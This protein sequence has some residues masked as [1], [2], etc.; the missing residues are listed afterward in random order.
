MTRLYLVRSKS[1]PHQEPVALSGLNL[2]VRAQAKTRGK[3]FPI[4]AFC[5]F[6]ESNCWQTTSKSLFH[7]S[8][9]L[10]E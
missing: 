3:K 2:F 4:V 9:H 1:L 5:S 10:I 8:P 6:V 7:P